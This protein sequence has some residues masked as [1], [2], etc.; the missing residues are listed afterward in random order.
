MFESNRKLLVV[1]DDPGIRTQLKWSFDKF[2]VITA[3]DRQHA[4]EAFNKYHP[5]VVTLDLGLP[6]DAEGSREGFEILRLILE[7]AP[8]TCVL[9]VSGSTENGTAQRAVECGAYCYFAKPV[10]IE[11]LSAAVEQAYLAYLAK[12]AKMQNA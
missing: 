12:K 11:K 5:P 8:Q 10:D 7:A 2:E 6:P 3:D 1:D 9:I 4:L